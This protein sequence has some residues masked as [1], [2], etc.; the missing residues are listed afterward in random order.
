GGGI[1][2]GVV[3][4]IWLIYVCRREA[5]RC[6]SCKELWACVHTSTE[7]LGNSSGYQTVTRTDHIR[8]SKGEVISTIDRQEQVHVITSCFARNYK[9]RFCDHKWY[10]T[11]STS[12][13]G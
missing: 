7:H 12:R 13:E 11:D 8:N 3:A 6:P 2:L 9:C 10:T 1:T 4:L 5:S